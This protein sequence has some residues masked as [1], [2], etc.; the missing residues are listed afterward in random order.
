MHIIDRIYHDIQQQI[1]TGKLTAGSQLPSLR[2]LA[3]TY[4]TSTGTV[5]QSL[6]R[7]RREGII[8]SHHGKGNFVSNAPHKPRHVML[9]SKLSGHLFSDFAAAFSTIFSRH[10]EYRLTLEAAPEESDDNAIQLLEKRVIN[11]IQNQLLDLIIIDGIVSAPLE[12]LKKVAHQTKIYY[13]H[14]PPQIPDL[15]GP[16]VLADYF[17]GGYMGIQHLYQRECRH[18]LVIT[19]SKELEMPWKEAQPFLAGCREAANMLELDLLF[20]HHQAE[21]PD[22]PDVFCELMRQNPQI[23]AIFALGDFRI[24]PLLPVLFQLDRKPGQDIALLGFYDTPWAQAMQPELS[25]ISICPKKI[26]EDLF[27]MIHEP[28]APQTLKMVQPQLV[29]RESTSGF[30]KT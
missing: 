21:F 3:S 8:T 18:P 23:D 19:Y 10:A 6:E 14:T 5:R 11:S 1:Q 17:H 12:F 25:S 30:H 4:E 28:Q 29:L 22:Y 2:K 20:L 24:R 27:L 15:L 16:Q 13:F 7:L 26:V 9:I